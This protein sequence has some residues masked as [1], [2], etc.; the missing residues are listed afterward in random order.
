MVKKTHDFDK[1]KLIHPLQGSPICEESLDLA[2]TWN[3]M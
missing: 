2:E 3:E 1:L